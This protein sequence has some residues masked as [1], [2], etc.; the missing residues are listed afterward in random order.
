MGKTPTMLKRK[1]VKETAKQRR[2]KERAEPKVL[3]GFGKHSL[4]D[5]MAEKDTDKGE[6]DLMGAADVHHWP[7]V[8]RRVSICSVEDVKL[9]QEYLVWVGEMLGYISPEEAPS[10]GP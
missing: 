7:P 1:V 8:Y 3:V 4:K 2:E 5:L 6:W 10:E 9:F